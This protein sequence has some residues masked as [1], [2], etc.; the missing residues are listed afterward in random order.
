MI[1]RF[2]FDCLALC[3]LLFLAANAVGCGASD[4]R[5]VVGSKKFTESV[6]LGEILA[7]LAQT[8]GVESEHKR[9]LG[10]T[11][12]VYD[13]L[14]V[15]DIDAYVEYTGT[16]AAELLAEEKFA[17]AN[18]EGMRVALRK[19]GIVVLDPLG[20]NNTYALAM[21]KERA[22]ELGLTKVSDLR[23]HP[24]LTFAFGNEFL[25][26]QD[27][28]PALKAAYSLPHD[29][30]RGMDHDLAYR[31]VA[32]GSRDIL[33]AYTTDAQ[34]AALDLVLLED[35]RKHFPDYRALLLLREEVAQDHPG[36]VEAWRRLSGAM[37]TAQMA[38]LNKRAQLDREP[39]RVVAASFI[40]DAFGIAVD[41]ESAASAN[42]FW[43]HT[44]DHLVLVGISLL[45]ALLFALPLGVAAAK[46]AVLRAPVLGAVSVMQTIPSLALLVV[47]IPI[48]G[49]G[50]A[51]AIVALFVYS[52][53]PVVRNTVAGLDG[54]PP[55]LDES[56]RA[57][58]LPAK[59]RLWK[60]ELPLALPSILAGIKTAAVINVGT[61]TLGAIIG[62][63]GYGQ[64]ILTGI[65]LGSTS[66]ILQG[67]IPAAILALLVSAFFDGVER[68]IVSDGLR[69]NL[70][71]D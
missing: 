65:R 67:A 3:W 25:E 51:P 12:V 66:L 41:T 71:S 35:D 17:A 24:S 60:V 13:A 20:F 10:G 37:N 59:T 7:A 54:V 9:E 47:L 52:L 63:G 56:A 70:K 69:A 62:A 16:I 2:R 55:A 14:L 45:L 34:I 57:L 46:V 44:R 64:P 28:W 42:G 8:N 29:D 26:R 19:K 11:R 58:G 33:D 21:R 43:T 32:E 48:L 53:L 68:V 23:R 36:V 30:V 50:A 40:K 18:V 15:G 4:A 5:L 6:V 27:G 61:A 49:V 1:S 38:A 31:A 39:E 22:A